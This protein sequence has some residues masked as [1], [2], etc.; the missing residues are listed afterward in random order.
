MNYQEQTSLWIKAKLFSKT[1][2]YFTIIVHDARNQGHLLWSGS[3]SKPLQW[4]NVLICRSKSTSS[5]NTQVFMLMTLLMA[6]VLIFA[7]WSFYLYDAGKDYAYHEITGQGR[8]DIVPHDYV[9][10]T[11]PEHSRG[12]RGGRTVVDGIL[13]IHARKCSCPDVRVVGFPA[14]DVE[15]ARMRM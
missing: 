11:L 2:R 12:G 7:K 6:S 8:P 15:Q 14:C 5:H 9:G 13:F 1:S 10:R 3:S 4:I